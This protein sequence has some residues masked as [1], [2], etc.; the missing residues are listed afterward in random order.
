M[1]D[2]KHFFNSVSNPITNSLVK[3]L[4]ED[5]VDYS[6]DYF[7]YSKVDDGRITGKRDEKDKDILYSKLFNY[8]KNFL[9]SY[10]EDVIRK[11]LSSD[12]TKNKEKLSELYE[13]LK[14]I[15]DV[16]TYA[17]IEALCKKNPILYEL[18]FLSY[19]KQQPTFTHVN[20]N[21]LTYGVMGL[22]SIDGRFYINIDSNKIDSFLK[23]YIGLCFKNNIP[24]YFKFSN[25]GSR[26]DTI[27]IYFSFKELETNLE[28]LNQIKTEHKEFELGKYK[29]SR[30]CGLVDGWLGYGS[31]PEDN[32]Q[33]YSSKRCDL[34][35]KSIKKPLF[36]WVFDNY[37]MEIPTS[38]G[39]VTLGYHISR[40]IVD[41]LVNKYKIYGDSL[42]EENGLKKADL[43][44][45]SFIDYLVKKVNSNFPF[46]LRSYL[47]N[48]YPVKS[49]NIA[50]SNNK[51]IN[52]EIYDSL[53]IVFS[54]GKKMIKT[55]PK[56]IDS[57]RIEILDSFKRAGINPDNPAF[58]IDDEI[59]F[60]EA[61]L[62]EKQKEELQQKEDVINVSNICNHF[63]SSYK[64][65]K[66][67]GP[68]GYEIS[69][70][71]YMQEVVFRWIPKD[72][73]FTLKNGSRIPYDKFIE[74]FILGIG[75]S[76][77]KGDIYKLLKDYTVM[78]NGFIINGNKVSYND[79]ID[80]VDSNIRYSLINVLGNYYIF[81]DYLKNNVLPYLPEDGMIS[82]KDG[83]YIN[84]IDFI[85]KYCFSGK[86]EDCNYDILDFMIHIANFD[87]SDIH[88]S[89][90]REC[91]RQIASIK[92]NND[93]P[94]VGSGSFKR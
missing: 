90:K 63:N 79:V 70:T 20:I 72:G 93:E 33:S 57:V 21:N 32:K 9:L 24:F 44:N 46:M 2:Y 81:E 30:L 56:L 78:N 5:E 6:Y 54:L 82:L 19:G 74:E 88:F 45:Q 85:N 11:W 26:N 80:S 49:I 16:S 43:S 7:T 25:D 87:Y 40:L 77:Y 47:N 51:S 94:D 64:D 15:N 53:D 55:D 61:E 86:I 31:E 42:L 37:N 8:W 18:S 4:I 10:D 50:T 89:W 91:E 58:N 27:V 60:K 22:D 76:E 71:Q 84:V 17:E 1:I 48:E 52:V 14:N 34:I 39:R 3:D 83:T 67:I 29:P 69:F 35:N 38:M 62:K 41:R 65:K 36:K 12:N 23:I 59:K 13:L 66:Y 28:I 92:K 75:Q 73:F 68:N